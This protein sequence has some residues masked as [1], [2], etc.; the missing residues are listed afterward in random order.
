MA[1]GEMMNHTHVFDQATEI[2]CRQNQVEVIGAIFLLDQFEP[3]IEIG[4]F[5]LHSLKLVVGQA[6]GPP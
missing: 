4:G 3:T 1:L 5:A 2:P 6:F